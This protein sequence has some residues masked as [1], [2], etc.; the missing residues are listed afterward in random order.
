MAKQFTVSFYSLDALFIVA[1]L[2]AGVNL[3]EIPAVVTPR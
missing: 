2:L 3:L 1:V